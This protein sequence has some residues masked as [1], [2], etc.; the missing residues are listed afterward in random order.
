[1]RSALY[2]PHTSID[3]IDL[4]K[5]ALLLWDQLEFIV[6]W[7]PFAPEYAEPLVARAMEVIGIPHCPTYDEQVETHRHI[8]ELVNRP[9]PPNFYY[10]TQSRHQRSVDA[11]EI[12]PQKF[13]N[14]TWDL[15]HQS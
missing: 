15:L 10:G 8:E 13:L 6:P 3:N 2:Y 1:M 7:K 11:Y 14:Q 9:L 5:T 12:Y 4:M